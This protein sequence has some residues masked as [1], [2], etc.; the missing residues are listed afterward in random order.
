MEGFK[1]GQLI[2]CCVA[3]KHELKKVQKEDKQQGQTVVYWQLK[4]EKYKSR[5][6]KH[7]QW[8]RI[9]LYI[10]LWLSSFHTETHEHISQPVGVF[11]LAY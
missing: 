2:I 4:M 8:D 10:W 6:G 3:Q 7:K 5:K 9:L 11:L 1:E